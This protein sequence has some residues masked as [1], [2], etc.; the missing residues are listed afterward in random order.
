[1]SQPTATFTGIRQLARTALQFYF[2]HIEVVGADN[3]PQDGAVLFCGNHQ[4][5]LIDPMMIICHSGRVVRFAAADILFSNPVLG[6]FFRR[7]QAVPIRRRQDHEGEKLDNTQAFDALYGVLRDGGAMGIFPEGISHRESDLS[8]FKTGPARMALGAKAAHP[9]QRVYIVP[10]GLYYSAPNRFRSAALLQLGGPIEITD[11]RVAAHTEDERAAVRQLTSDLEN[12]VRALTVT[13]DDWETIHTLDAARRLYQPD[14]IPLAARVELARRFN[15][16]FPTVKDEPDVA[17]FLARMQQYMDLLGDLGLKDREVRRLSDKKSRRLA[18]AK[19]GFSTAV[20]TP[21]ALLGAPLHVPLF[22]FIGWGGRRFSPRYD[23][24]GTTKVVAG[25]LLTMAAYAVV[26]AGVFVVE[27]P[28][29]AIG[30]SLGLPVLGWAFVA[31][32]H[33]VRSILRL[34]RIT[35]A[36]LVVGRGIFDRLGAERAALRDELDGLITTHVPDDMDR[37]FEPLADR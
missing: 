16:V 13:A 35:A 2:R 11:E 24:I 12:D 14:G 33:R 22:A 3:V 26:A 18:A 10:C 5:S 37:L 21:F 25:M 27:G 6:F 29:L 1:V 36:T 19:L 34:S 7:L 28:R 20:L 30:V 4:N 15:Q 8:E 23:V 9:Q 17:A 31:W 32:L